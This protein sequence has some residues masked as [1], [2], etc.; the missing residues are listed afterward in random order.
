MPSVTWMPVMIHSPSGWSYREEQENGDQVDCWSCGNPLDD[1]YPIV[2]DR[3]GY[4][5]HPNCLHEER[6]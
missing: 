1:D 5:Y 6:N 2:N 4:A 3:E